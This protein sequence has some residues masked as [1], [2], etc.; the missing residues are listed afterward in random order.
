[1]ATDKIADITTGITDGLPVTKSELK[2]IVEHTLQRA[3]GEH[4]FETKTG[5]AFA[6]TA[7]A[8]W[9]Q[10]TKL[11]NLPIIS[12]TIHKHFNVWY[13]DGTDNLY[14]EDVTPG[15]NS[16][17]GSHTLNLTGAARTA[18]TKVIGASGGQ[19]D[20]TTAVENNF[21]I[22]ENRSTTVPA[23]TADTVNVV[24]SWTRRS[25]KRTC[26]SFISPR[27]PIVQ[28]LRPP[29]TRK[30]R[31]GRRSQCT[32]APTDPQLASS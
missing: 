32:P 3:K 31:C 22:D 10:F 25:Q 15:Y 5:G 8:I 11:A 26:R 18:G 1:M 13:T 14:W 19:F 27:R 12:N 28:N 4:D 30:R 21:R 24:R 29:E 17:D 16:G 7:T 20:L 6:V 23:V 9:L 2:T